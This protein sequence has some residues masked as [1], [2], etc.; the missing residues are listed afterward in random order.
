MK[1]PEVVDH[2][3]RHGAADS[4][5]AGSAT[6]VLSRVTGRPREPS[7][8]M[9]HRGRLDSP[10]FRA[11]FR[12]PGRPRHFVRRQRLLTMLDELTDYPVT[13]IVAPAGAGKTV[14]AADWLTYSSY[15]SAWLTLDSADQDVS[16]LRRSLVT[17]L[18][19]LVPGTITDLGGLHPGEDLSALLARMPNA[20]SPAD[21]MVLV[22][23]NLERLEDDEPAGAL[24]TSFVEH[25]PAWLRLVLLSRRRPPVPI[26]R[27][28]GSGEL[29]DIHFGALRFSGTEAAA[30]LTGLCPD[31]PTAELRSAAD[32]AN[33]WAA[34]LQLTALAIRSHQ[35]TAQP[36]P[37]SSLYPG[38]ERLVEEYL[39][40]EVLRPERPELVE[41]LLS[42][43]IVGRINY[44]LAETLTQRPDAGDL[45]E[46]AEAA[47]LF[48]TALEG[49]WFELHSLVREMLTGRLERRWP[50]GLRELHAR[51]AQWFEGVGDP[52][53]SLDHWLLADRST[54]ALRV[55][56]EVSLPLLEAGRSAQ[57][58]D[59]ID[60][61]PVETA[62]VDPADAIRYAWCQLAAG[63]SAYLNGLSLAESSAASILGP[64]RQRMET[65][66]AVAS[67]LRADWH[68]AE[69][70]AQAALREPE[71]AAADVLERF[72]WHLVTAGIAL[73]ERWDDFGAPVGEARAACLRDPTVRWAFEGTRAVGLALAGRPLE[74]LRVTDGARRAAGTGRFETLRIELALAEAL[75]ARELDH[76][77]EARGALEDLAGTPTYPNPILQLVARLELVRLRMDAG[78]LTAAAAELEEAEHLYGRLA[79]A[80][81]G[82][83]GPAA[84]T[85]ED[86]ASD[87]VARA[88][89]DLALAR[90]D[91]ATAV[92]W[93]AHLSDPFWGP[94]AAAKISLARDRPEEAVHALERAIPRCPRHQVIS[95][96]LHGRAL[97]SSSRSAA[98]EIVSSTLDLAAGHAMLRTVADQGAPLMELVELAA[99][100]VPDEWMD[101]LRHALVPTWSCP[102]PQRLIEDLTDRE[103]E[104]LRLLPSRLTLAEIASELYVS[105]NTLKFHLRGIYRKLGAVSRA[106]A[107]DSA[108]HMR[109]LPR[110]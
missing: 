69:V 42:T 102:D 4:D 74:A 45:L 10:F 50:S 61:I 96:L 9:V 32:R 71:A 78:D 103:R 101:R 63:R 109:L 75:V 16:E 46:D 95:G 79:S 31:L 110:G 86:P 20:N 12:V 30:L 82:A 107:V 70:H 56:S 92:R 57:V 108:R 91:P 14:L 1:T 88:G 80:A 65:L 59:A 24:L 36:K 39:W 81:P 23:D 44:G 21:P 22:I 85:S 62:T 53:A 100:R 18:D 43:A 38:T 49:G 66:R 34:A 99:W 84:V 55:L 5:A 11:K 52:L 87:L 94:V 104:V 73:D 35:F 106:E 89:V 77:D 2:L 15:P 8:S 47:G 13:A 97:A 67:W 105:Q 26:V 25:R 76:R 17:A 54:E 98:E 7:T 27:L 60:R 29:A 93:V 90:D 64:N 41:L 40:E 51:A 83:A 3:R 72:G 48:V 37:M 68:R 6:D 28:R 58:V 33:G 19:I